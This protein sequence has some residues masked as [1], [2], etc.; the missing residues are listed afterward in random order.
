[1][2]FEEIEEKNS[3][4]YENG[5]EYVYAKDE[6]TISLKKIDNDLMNLNTVDEKINYLETSVVNN[7]SKN[8]FYQD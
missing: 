5:N 3:R 2:H 4:V 7:N 8:R 6:T 1:M